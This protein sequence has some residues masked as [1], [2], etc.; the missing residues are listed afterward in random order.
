M[1]DVITKTPVTVS[2][3]SIPKTDQI[4]EATAPI[5][6]YW[7]ILKYVIVILLLAFLGIN[8][9]DALGKATDTTTSVFG[10]LL[11]KL[12]FGV[13]ETVKNVVNVSA[14]GTKIGIDVAAGAA[15]DAVTLL[16]KGV[17]VKNVKFNRIDKSANKAIDTSIKNKNNTPDPAPDEATSSTQ[18]HRA[19]KSGV[20]FIGE[21]RGFRSCIKVNEGEQCM[22]GDIF[23]TMDICVNPNLRE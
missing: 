6:G 14:K 16:E 5:S 1:D 11:A 12:G 18:R 7:S 21:D 19:N 23:P 13:G 4:I 9:F 10:P 20:C 2:Y 3:I 17:G 15:D 22:S 8:I